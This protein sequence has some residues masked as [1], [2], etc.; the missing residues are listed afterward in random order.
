MTP[1]RDLTDEEWQCI[2]PLLPEMRPRADMRGRPLIDTRGVLNGVLWVI[3]SGAIWAAMPE[4]Y[5]SYQ[6]CH[7]RFKR[8]H[9]A[10]VL[11]QVLGALYGH[12]GVNLSDVLGARMRSRTQPKVAAEPGRTR[13]AK[14]R[15]PG[16]RRAARPH[17]TESVTQA[18]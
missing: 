18:T 8:W 10:G 17:G 14:G 5:P 7:R 16:K 2:E 1:Y 15:Q 12:V 6:T 9:E 4:R 11:K 3:H 13:A